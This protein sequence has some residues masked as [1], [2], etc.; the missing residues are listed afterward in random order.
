[1][2]QLEIPPPSSPSPQKDWNLSKRL[3]FLPL[4]RSVSPY[5]TRFCNYVVLPQ[6][7]TN[8]LTS[9]LCEHSNIEERIFQWRVPPGNQKRNISYGDIH[10]SSHQV[11]NDF[12]PGKDT[13]DGE[14]RWNLWTTN[15]NRRTDLPTATS[16]GQDIYAAIPPVT[17]PTATLFDLMNKTASPNRN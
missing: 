8:H 12:F 15:S 10:I 4:S 2:S 3:Q 16:M 17:A 14:K 11:P 6:E 13:E 7:V 5:Q 1:M 9:E